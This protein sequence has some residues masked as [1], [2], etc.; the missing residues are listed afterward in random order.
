MDVKFEELTD[1]QQQAA[2]HTEG[3]LLVL[4]GAGTG[5]TTTLR[6]RYQK[7]L[8][9]PDINPENILLTTFTRNAAQ[10]IEERVEGIGEEDETHIGTVHSQFY[11]LMKNHAERFGYD[12][13]ESLGVYNQWE[14]EDLVRDILIDQLPR[15]ESDYDDDLLKN[16]VNVFA[17]NLNVCRRELIHPKYIKS[18]IEE[19]MYELR[20]E[21]GSEDYDIMPNWEN[22]IQ[23]VFEEYQEKLKDLNAVDFSAMQFHAYQLFRDNNDILEA[24][25]EKFQYIIVDEAQ[26]LS[27]LQWRLIDLIA[28]DHGQLALIADDAQSIYG[29]RGSNYE[30]LYDFRDKYDAEV[31]KITT[32]YRSSEQ[33]LEQ[34]NNISKE[35]EDG[36]EEK[37]LDS[38]KGELEESEGHPKKLQFPHAGREKAWIA[39]KVDELVNDEGVDPGE[40]GIITRRTRHLYELYNKIRFDYEIPAYND[41]GT[42]FL[43]RDEVKYVLDF[44][45][46]YQEPEDNV[47]MERVLKNYVNSVGDKT[48]RRIKDEKPYGEP[49]VEFIKELKAS[50]LDGVGT[51]T[52]SKLQNAARFITELD[53]KQDPMG[54]ILAEQGRWKNAAYTSIDWDNTCVKNVDKLDKKLNNYKA[55]NKETVS[56]FLDDITL[57]EHEEQKGKVFLS[58]VHGA[59]G[60]E[61]EAVFVPELVDRIFPSGLTD[62]IEEEKRLFYVAVSRA[63]EKCF[64]SYNSQKG[65]EPSPFLGFVEGKVIPKD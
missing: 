16:T 20:T 17:H 27:K 33:I 65:Q 46:V 30:Y 64:L 1:A 48:M 43:E 12:D 10:E 39:R 15:N 63:K 7:L 28:E 31:V 58:T 13:G 51:G 14:Q 11:S 8:E 49:I 6:H 56:E 57:S 23:P 22:L 25:Q 62:D 42:D 50:D 36:I 54:E 44:L 24:Y 18:S 3:A 52:L 55:F 4:A 29:W 45:R 59:K 5:K 26:D 21:I 40:I 37:I 61:W 2:E 41:K 60:K 38:W 35:L 53:S 32:N 19:E 47:K 34:V 9:E